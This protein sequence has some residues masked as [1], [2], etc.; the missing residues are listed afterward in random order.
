MQCGVLG[1]ACA[2]VRGARRRLTRGAGGAPLSPGTA[3]ADDS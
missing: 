3:P 1:G 2:R